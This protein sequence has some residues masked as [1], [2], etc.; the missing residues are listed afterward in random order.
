MFSPTLPNYTPI[1]DIL[2]SKVSVGRL[3]SVAGIAVDFRL[4]TP[5]RKTGE[6]EISLLQLVT[7]NTPRLEVPNPTL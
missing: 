4:P 2:D 3:V 6:N 7:S 1:R 5:T